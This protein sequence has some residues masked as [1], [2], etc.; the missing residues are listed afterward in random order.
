MVQR[1]DVIVLQDTSRIEVMYK[2][3]V[4]IGEVVVD[5][6]HNL[7]SVGTALFPGVP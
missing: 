1:A 2:V 5:N 7:G 4:G 3:G 6:V